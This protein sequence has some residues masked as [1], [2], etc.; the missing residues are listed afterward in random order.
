[1]TQQS[2]AVMQE[3]ERNFDELFVPADRFDE[4]LRRVSDLIARRAFE[5]FESRGHVHGHDWEDWYRAEATVL[6]TI[7][8][9]V[10]DSGDAFCA[11][12]DISSYRPQD[13]KLS[14]ERQRLRIVGCPTLATN[15]SGARENATS[16]PRA[17]SLT[18]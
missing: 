14:A 4:H 3:S 12:V 13:L 8:N 16:R 2:A 1:M 7:N 11:V 6:Q 5:I 17:F 9:E 18:Y 10:S 15:G